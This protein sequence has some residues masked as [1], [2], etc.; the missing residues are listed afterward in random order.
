MYLNIRRVVPLISIFLWCV[1][2]FKI[3]SIVG[4]ATLLFCIFNYSN[5]NFSSNALLINIAT[6]NFLFVSNFILGFSNLVITG[7][8]IN[9]IL[10]VY[11]NYVILVLIIQFALKRWRTET[12]LI[13]IS[14]GLLSFTLFTSLYTI[15]SVKKLYGM[16]S[17]HNPLFGEEPLGSALTSNYLIFSLL[18]GYHA[19]KFKTWKF[20]FLITYLLLNLYLGART[21]F[22]ILLLF[23]LPSL[24]Y[25]KSFIL[26][27]SVTVFLMI[28][29]NFKLSEN[30]Y[31]LLNVITNKGIESAR[32]SHWEY[33]LNN[34]SNFPLGGLQ[35]NR[36]IE[37][38]GSF[39]NII[40]DSY[41]LSGII[42]LTSILV[43]F[44]YSIFSVFPSKSAFYVIL[45]MFAVLNQDV[46]FEGGQK[47]L[48]LYMSYSLIIS[49]KLRDGI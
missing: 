32:W 21:G 36:N 33:A 40:L 20:G 28:L 35:V 2:P 9:L 49:K 27:A 31:Y 24:S 38:I 23:V 16:G 29:T 12:I 37:D 39:H 25:K 46:I 18:Y 15:I 42:G 30:L 17:V 43:L 45:L 34:F 41:R 22:I 4:L 13:T 11:L 8:K 7:N 6:F 48:V 10:S 3:W 1:L 44:T 47:L 14:I 26:I 5:Y 19:L